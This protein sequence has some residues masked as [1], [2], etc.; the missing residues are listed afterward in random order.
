M[1]A[2]VVGVQVVQSRGSARGMLAAMLLVLP[3]SAGA[4]LIAAALLR[5]L[6]FTLLLDTAVLLLAGVLLLPGALL[7]AGILPGAACCRS[8]LVQLGVIRRFI[9]M[10]FVF[11]HVRLLALVSGRSMLRRW[12][13]SPISVLVETS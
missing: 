6:L 10:T 1:T 4:L 9:A 2:V 13:T 7:I 8:L 11:T 5:I 3:L 12:R